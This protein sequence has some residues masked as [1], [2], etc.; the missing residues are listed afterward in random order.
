M[1]RDGEGFFSSEVAS[2]DPETNN[3][4]RFKKSSGTTAA[5]IQ[6]FRQDAH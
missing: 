3:G 4:M 5:S 6:R 2:D 1:S